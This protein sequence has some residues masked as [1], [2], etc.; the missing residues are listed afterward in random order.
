[1]NIVIVNRTRSDMSLTLTQVENIVGQS[2]ALGF[3]PAVELAFRSYDMSSPMV[4]IQPDS[5]IAQQFGILVDQIAH[6]VHM[7]A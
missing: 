6:R 1:M 2:V 3:P 4:L 5:M 7:A